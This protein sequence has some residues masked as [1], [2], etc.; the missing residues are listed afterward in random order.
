MARFVMSDDLLFFFIH[1]SFLLFETSHK[2]VNCLFEFRHTY[3]LLIS[4]CCEQGCFVDEIGKVCPDKSRSHACNG[5]Q[6]DFLL[7][8]YPFCMYLKDCFSPVEVWPINNHLAI[9][10][11]GSQKGGV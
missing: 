6:I 1:Q 5:V 10:P 2:A 4:P 11:A 8:F 3:G 9:K 7:Q